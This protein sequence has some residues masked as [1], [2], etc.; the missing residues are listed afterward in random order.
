MV[1]LDYSHV[2]V[3]SG[4]SHR[5][6]RAVKHKIIDRRL[7]FTNRLVKIPFQASVV[8]GITQVDHIRSATAKAI[9]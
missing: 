2:S 1:R 9:M 5:Y 4:Q 6:R 3:E 7:K 8:I